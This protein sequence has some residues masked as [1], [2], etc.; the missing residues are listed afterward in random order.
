MEL[1]VAIRAIAA[2]P[3]AST[4]VLTTDSSYVKDGVTKWIPVLKCNEWVTSQEE[5]VKNQDL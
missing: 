1:M 2:L 3:K 4:I 5:H